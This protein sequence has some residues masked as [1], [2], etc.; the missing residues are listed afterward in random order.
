MISDLVWIV[1]IVA[2]LAV[3][4]MLLAAVRGWKDEKQRRKPQAEL[5]ADTH[6]FYDEEVDCLYDLTRDEPFLDALEFLFW[7]AVVSAIGY[8]LIWW[9]MG[10]AQLGW[11]WLSTCWLGIIPALCFLT[12]ARATDEEGGGWPTWLV[13][14]AALVV[15]YLIG[16]ILWSVLAVGGTVVWTWSWYEDWYKR[17]RYLRIASK[18]SSSSTS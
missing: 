14:V 17:R 10:F 11:G 7:G 6:L 18:R 3:V 13:T 1:P 5:P 15:G 4:V 12:Y 9:Q 2:V 16:Q 8:G